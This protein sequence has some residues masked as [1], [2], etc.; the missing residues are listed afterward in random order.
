LG[1]LGGSR[2]W[3][4]LWGLGHAEMIAQG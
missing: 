4:G 3:L 2:L 1:G